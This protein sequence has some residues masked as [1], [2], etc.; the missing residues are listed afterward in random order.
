MKRILTVA[1]AL[2]AALAAAAMPAEQ[3]AVPPPQPL[4]VEGR[5]TLRYRYDSVHFTL[6]TD[7]A[8]DAYAG[9]LQGDLEQYFSHF[10]KEYWDFIRP[11]HREAHI[12]LASVGTQNAYDA[13]AKSDAGIPRGGKGYS[14]K[15]ANRI[16]FLRQDEYYKDITIVVHELTHV[17]NRFSLQSTPIWLDEGMAQYYAN[18]AGERCG[19]TNITDGI[20]KASLEIVNDAARDNSLV[21]VS[22]LIKMKDE[23][24]YGGNSRLNYAECWTLVYYLR[25]G[26]PDGDNTLA[27]FY[28]ELARNADAVRAFEKVYGNNYK[29]LQ[30]EWLTFVKSLYIQVDAASERQPEN[31]GRTGKK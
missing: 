27:K 29:A 25:K 4:L 17:F 8:D 14:N 26:I 16:G 10:Q 24:F 5:W 18:Y 9:R 11:E 12:D 20:Q 1:A 21:P 22:L 23:E 7:F 28:D 2:A 19:N 6:Y 30:A 31:A 3:K 15:S 13:I